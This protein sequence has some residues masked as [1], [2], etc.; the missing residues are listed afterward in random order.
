[1]VGT[2]FLR[3]IG[4]GPWAVCWQCVMVAVQIRMVLVGVALVT[5][6][7]HF[8]SLNTFRTPCQCLKQSCRGLFFYFI[9]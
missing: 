5:V 2:G 3:E 6:M 9:L 4:M 1:M 8:Q 7:W